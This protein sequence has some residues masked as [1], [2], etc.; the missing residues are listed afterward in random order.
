MNFSAPFSGQLEDE[1]IRKALAK[2]PETI[3]EATEAWKSIDAVRSTGLAPTFDEGP[4]DDA[5]RN[6]VWRPELQV[7]MPTAGGLPGSRGLKKVWQ[8]PRNENSINSGSNESAN[9]TGM[10]LGG[11]VK[12]L[13]QLFEN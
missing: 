13:I 11:G 5:V 8:Y 2:L 9:S 1:V 10:S 3:A 4:L 12:N 6:G 7:R